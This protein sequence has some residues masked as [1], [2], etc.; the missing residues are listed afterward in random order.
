MSRFGA[1]E[2]SGSEC[3]FTQLLRVKVREEEEGHG[4]I[5][6]RIQFMLLPSF[7]PLGG[8]SSQVTSHR[9]SFLFHS[10]AKL[11]HVVESPLFA[12]KFEP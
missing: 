4:V 2:Q 11:F 9:K 7:I 3:S 5:S 8:F 12:N 1:L 6:G 10:P